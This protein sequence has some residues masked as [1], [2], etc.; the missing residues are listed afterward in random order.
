MLKPF[1]QGKLDAFCA[2]YAVIN[3]FRLTNGIRTARAMEI[4]NEALLAASQRPEVF[5]AILYQKTDYLTLVDW[6][7]ESHKK[8]LRLDVQKPF[9][10]RPLPSADE[11]WTIC[12][13]WLNGKTGR[14]IV[15]RFL[16]YIT[17]DKAPIN[18]HWTTADH[19]DDEIL[20]L[21]DC[22][23]EAEAILN[24]HRGTFVTRHN[25]LDKDHL[26]YIPPEYVRF[27][28]LAA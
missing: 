28:Q 23:H 18:R 6:L 12:Q 15:F 13:R 7:L 4:L 21:F 3:A 17:P 26:L 9:E 27:L 24:V 20:H 11:F 2:I 1:Y 8:Q 22:S 10:N 14:A 19:M 25:E 5:R 16:R